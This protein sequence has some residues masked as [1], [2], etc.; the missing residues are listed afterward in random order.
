ML[1]LGSP[2]EC[3]VKSKSE[4]EPQ[5]DLLEIRRQLTVTRSLHSN[6]RRVTIRINNLIGE[7]AV[8]R[9]PDDR[10]HEKHL[11]RSP[12]LCERLSGSF[13]A[14]SL[15][16]GRQLRYRPMQRRTRDKRRLTI[17]SK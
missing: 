1:L 10:A 5:L 4:F 8:L 16:S 9:Q 14:I 6:N 7:L 15:Q 17:T 12:R 13:R 11:I 2:Q 3:K